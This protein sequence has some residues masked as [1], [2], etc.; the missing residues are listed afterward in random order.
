MD[1]EVYPA[2]RHDNASIDASV[3]GQQMEQVSAIQEF[4]RL[5]TRKV[6]RRF[7]VAA[8]GHQDSFGG[9]FVLNGAEEVPHGADADC[10]L[11]ALRLD[12]NLSA[13]TRPGVE[14]DAIDVAVTRRTCLP[15][16]YEAAW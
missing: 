14:G 15:C 4:K 6:E 16:R 13:E 8:G 7:S 2:I 3:L 10:V 11:V 9:T 5:T 1:G 12:D